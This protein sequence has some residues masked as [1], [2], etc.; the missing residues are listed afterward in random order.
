[1]V[2]IYKKIDIKLFLVVS[3]DVSIFHAY[4]KTILYFSFVQ[5]ERKLILI[6]RRVKKNVEKLTIF[7]Q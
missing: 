7:R 2:F 1:M 6:K 5:K 4:R 3:T